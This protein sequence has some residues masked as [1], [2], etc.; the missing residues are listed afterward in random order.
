[1]APTFSVDFQGQTKYIKMA[2]SSSRKR[3]KEQVVDEEEDHEEASPTKQARLG[4]EEEEEEAEV[5]LEAEEEFGEEG[6][7]EQAEEEVEEMEE[8]DEEEE[9][10]E[11][12]APKKVNISGK[13]AEAGIIKRVQVENF[14]CHRK[15]TVDLC[16]NGVCY[17]QVDFESCM[18]DF[19]TFTIISLSTSDPSQ[20]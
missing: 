11:P 19:L 18:H 3:S 16:P 14:M 17:L 1:M 6:G 9:E 13:P 10:E 4:D 2:P 20:S 15:L 12:F 5:E 7:N 8:D